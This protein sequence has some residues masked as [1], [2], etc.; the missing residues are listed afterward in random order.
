MDDIKGLL[1][2]RRLFKILS[3]QVQNFA[4]TQTDASHDVQRPAEKGAEPFRPRNYPVGA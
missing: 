2:M 1:R 3:P 4:V